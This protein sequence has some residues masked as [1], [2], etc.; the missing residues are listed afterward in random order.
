MDEPEALVIDKDKDPVLLHRQFKLE[1]EKI[2]E[3]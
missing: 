3:E 1:E 2:R